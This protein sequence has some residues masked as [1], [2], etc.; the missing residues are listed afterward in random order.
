MQMKQ[1]ERAHPS[2][3]TIASL[4]FFSASSHTRTLHRS[5]ASIGPR[6]QARQMAHRTRGVAGIYPFTAR[7]RIYSLP[8]L[9]HGAASP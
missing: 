9:S 8:L 6:P 7:Q 1:S 2:H 5:H 4:Q 3:R